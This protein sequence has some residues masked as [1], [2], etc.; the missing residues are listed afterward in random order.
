MIEESVDSA[1][2]HLPGSPFEGLP[3]LPTAVR[4]DSQSSK[5]HTVTVQDIKTRRLQVPPD[6]RTVKLTKRMTFR[7][8]LEVEKAKL[9]RDPWVL[10]PSGHPAL[11]WWDLGTVI[12][13]VFVALITPA[14]VALLETKMDA[15]FVINR[16]IDLVFLIDM[17]LQFCVAYRVKT[18]YGSRLE[19]RRNIIVRH[20]L[21]TWFCVD[22][23]SIVPFDSIGM[24]AQSMAL[25][26]AKVTKVLRLLRL[27]KLVR[28]LR[29]SRVFRRWETSMAWNYNTM[30]LVF[31][32][33]VFLIASHWIACVW[34]M[35]ALQGEDGRTWIFHAAPREGTIPS[36]PWEVYITSLYWSAMTVTSVGYGDIVPVNIEERIVCTLLMFASGFLWAYALGETMASLGQSNVHEKK[37]REMLD[38]LNQMMADR[39][40]NRQL[41]RR[42]RSFFFQIKDLARVSGYRTLV[43]HLSPALK[44]ELSMTVNEVWMRKV[45]YF[46]CPRLS[47]SSD[48]LQAL[49]TQLQ[50]SVHVQQES[51]GEPWTLYIL[52]RGLCVRR[53]TFMKSGSVWGE[54]FILASHKLL[55]TSQAFCL[56]FIEVS[57]LTRRRFSEIVKRFP[58]VW[59]PVRGAV[60][61]TAIRR[62]VIMEATKRLNRPTR[63][64]FM[65]F[66]LKG[67][68]TSSMDQSMSENFP[69]P[70]VLEETLE[71]GE[72]LQDVAAKQARIQSQLDETRTVLGEQL[73]R[74]EDRLKVLLPTAAGDVRRA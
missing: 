8:A 34:A 44:G 1:V 35:M 47:M 74:I 53:M 59:R 30:K 72:R 9:H 23:L 16:L 62:G 14:E 6:W 24:L 4:E 71:V 32:F 69:L 5:R 60:V 41:Q 27:I 15:L 12:C 10:T 29:A 58:E 3:S 45:W 49:S 7:E 50:V 48:F 43:D 38:D 65:S 33:A 13:L 70:P 52:H 19:T 25:E 73:L 36:T 31:A 56:T 21:R 66:A 54:D 68:R 39:G 42:L 28:V 67:T 64:E 61:R 57:R 20:Y 55:D 22:L 37:F 46:S 2:Q 18:P 26:R 63:R 51:F 11:Q 17:A 40:L